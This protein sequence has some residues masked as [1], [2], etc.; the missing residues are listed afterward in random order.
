MRD[1][2]AKVFGSLWG[3]YS[4]KGNIIQI[5][6]N[7]AQYEE[8]TDLSEFSENEKLKF[9]SK[10]YIYTEKDGKKVGV[11]NGAHFFTIGQRRGLGVGGLK[12]PG[13]VI[14]TDIKTNII[15]IGEGKKHPGLFRKGLF[16]KQNEIHYIR[17]DL[18][19]KIDD[20]IKLKVRIRYRQSLQNAKIF[21]KDEGMYIVFDELQRGITPGQ[22]AALY[23]DDELIAS[24]VIS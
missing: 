10:Q 12:E 13:F 16:I 4:K 8:K 5:P 22:F 9:W 6:K 17:E 11:H 14:D 1:K 15:Y 7:F 3:A 21:M 2:T 19:F 24:G 23:I 20:K 18:R